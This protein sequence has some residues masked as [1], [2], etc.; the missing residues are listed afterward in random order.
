MAVAGVLAFLPTIFQPPVEVEV[1]NLHEKSLGE[2]IDKLD[3]GNTKEYNDSLYALLKDKL[4]LYHA[5]EF[6]TYDQVDEYTRTF[7]NEYVMLFSEYCNSVFRQSVWRKADHR[8]MGKRVAD[9]KGLK[10]TDGRTSPLTESH[11]AALRK[12]TN[13]I[14]DY[15]EANKL[16][17]KTTFRDVA[18]ANANISQAR[19]FQQRDPLCNCQKLVQ[20]LSA[21]PEKLGKSHYDKVW[22]EIRKTLGNYY[23]MTPEE[24]EATN[25]RIRA[26]I[27]EY[28]N[29]CANYG[30]STS[31][32]QKLYD[33]ARDI[34]RE[35]TNYYENQRNI[36][37]NTNGQWGYMSSPDGGYFA[38]R[39]ESNYCRS[40][41]DAEMRVTISGYDSFTFYIRSNGEA[42]FDY[43]MV[44]LNQR[45]TTSSNRANTKGRPSSGTSRSSYTPVTFNNLSRSSTYTIYIVYRKDG[46]DNRGDDRGYVLIPRQ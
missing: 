40:G 7:V 18:T 37:I 23:Y 34:Y 31:T 42:D 41:Y 30:R 44:G 38:Y 33:E 17:K 39:S 43:V 12:V 28:K 13:T 36:S 8:Y 11:T 4:A 6:M 35:A 26:K 10:L 21:Y 27:D 29:N 9:L 46:S 25:D 24:F 3:I 32:A 20:D 2:D 22:N 1:E 16:L 14:R 15:D 19:L 5:E 45:P